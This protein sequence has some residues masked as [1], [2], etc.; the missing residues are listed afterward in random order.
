MVNHDHM[1]A[2][3]PNGTVNHF[4]ERLRSIADTLDEDPTVS[5]E[6]ND[7][8]GA[9]TLRYAETTD[10]LIE[11]F[12]ADYRE[13]SI[14]LAGS[15][16]PA[17]EAVRTLI[18][19]VCD[20]MPRLIRL[21][22]RLRHSGAEEFF[23]T[24]EQSPRQIE[25]LPLVAQRL[26]DLS[27]KKRYDFDEEDFKSVIGILYQLIYELSRDPDYKKSDRNPPIPIHSGTRSVWCLTTKKI[28]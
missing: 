11:E 2:R 17:E 6:I 4:L 10:K 18:W 28:V 27:E 26:A 24:T 16:L 5:S 25:R 13:V 12:E 21:C 19:N 22:N 9:N 15:E 20:L 1:K 14:A 3:Y 23:R 8:T 7:L